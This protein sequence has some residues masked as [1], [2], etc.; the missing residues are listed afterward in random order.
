MEVTLKLASKPGIPN[1]NGVIY[2]K[3]TF[4]KMF[5]SDYTK[6]LLD[7]GWLYITKGDPVIRN[8]KFCI[9]MEDCIGKVKEWKESDIVV[10]IIK[11]D[12]V[13]LLE[14]LTKQNKI[15]LGMNYYCRLEKRKDNLT[16]AIGMRID[17]M[18]IVNK[19]TKMYL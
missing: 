19:D 18:S 12:Y 4:E 10:D 1:R 13:T 16:E 7:N 15:E 5:N 3:E 8:Q 6:E 9:S 17:S 11:S 14:E 2:S